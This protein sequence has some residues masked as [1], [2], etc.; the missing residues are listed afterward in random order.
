MR[1]KKSTFE[2]RLISPSGEPLYFRVETTEQKAKAQADVLKSQGYK[3]EWAQAGQLESVA[4]DA[5]HMPLFAG[6][7]FTGA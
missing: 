2:F 6:Q 1:P 7:L 5:E 3:V 4:R